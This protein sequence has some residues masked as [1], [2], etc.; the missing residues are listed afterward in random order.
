MC[1]PGRPMELPGSE[2]GAILARFLRCVRG[3]R[4]PRPRRCPSTWEMASGAFLG[5][6]PSLHP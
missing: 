6:N 1:S 4:E 5:E 2:R 3:I